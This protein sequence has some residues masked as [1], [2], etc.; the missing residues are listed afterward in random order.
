M[1]Y[2]GWILIALIII[3]FLGLA[4][5]TNLLRDDVDPVKLLAAAKNL[6]P[7]LAEDTSPDKISRPFS[8]SRVQLAVWTTVIACVYCY[9]AFCC[10]TD[11]AQIGF[12][13]TVLALMGVSVGTAAVGSA[14]DKSENSSNR[15]QNDGPS[16]GIIVD[17]LSDEN[18]ISVHRFQN[19]VW[20]IISISIFLSGV[21]SA[22]AACKLPVLD[23]TLLIL[24]G[25][26]S[27]T[28]VALKAGENKK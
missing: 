21:G 1:I 24:M 15:H 12:N 14:I 3:L 2:V 4:F 5:F 20:T 27:G 6:N 11:I 25:I 22:A 8:L 10:C 26:S 17:I 7:N 18:G 19:V 16:Q 9:T 13:A 23:Q 28:Y